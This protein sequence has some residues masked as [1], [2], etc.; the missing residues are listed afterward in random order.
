MTIAVTWDCGKVQA[1]YRWTAA[2]A[3]GAGI[4]QG[5]EF[6]RHRGRNPSRKH[7]R[8]AGAIREAPAVR[9]RVLDDGDQRT[10]PAGKGR[11]PISWRSNSF[12]S[13]AILLALLI[14]IPT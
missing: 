3:T 9:A 8:L 5:C 12:I 11:S 13:R 4:G 6:Y 10:H 14:E 2:G 1:I 7:S